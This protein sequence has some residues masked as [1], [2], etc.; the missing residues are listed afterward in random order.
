[1]SLADQWISFWELEEA[2]GTRVDQVTATGND[3]TDNN[4]VTQGTGIVGN[5][6]QFTRANSESLSHASNASLQFTGSW[7]ITAWFLKDSEPSD[8]TIVGKNNGAGARDFEMG[9]SYAGGNI[10]TVD[11]W[12]SGVRVFIDTAATITATGVWHHVV[13]SFDSA[14]HIMSLYL[15]NAAALTVDTG[16]AAV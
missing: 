4:T 3:L 5:C 11:V 16:V 8:M 15:D 1:M 13:V 9:L 14:T 12:V 6:A 7:S 10:L 2:S